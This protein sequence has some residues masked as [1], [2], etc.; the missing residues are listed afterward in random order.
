MRPFKLPDF[1]AAAKNYIEGLDISQ[2][3]HHAFQVPGVK[4][5][6]A[7][8][9]RKELIKYYSGET[10]EEAIRYNPAK[11]G[12]PRSA[13]DTLAKNAINYE[14]NKV[15]ALS[16]LASL[17]GGIAAIGSVSADL[18]S[19]YAHILRIVQK[20][21]YLYGFPEFQLSEDS[22]D[23]ETLNYILVFIGI[24][25]GVHGAFETA[26]MIAA[27]VADNIARKLP[28]KA[29]N[30]SVINPILG[31]I[32][33]RIGSKASTQS[34]ADLFASAVPV[35]GAAFSGGLTYATFKP[36]CYKLRNTLRKYRLCDPEF[37]AEK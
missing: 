4:I 10:V 29:L 5:D 14:T 30:K 15:T 23:E 9:L 21:A 24:M 18:V 8:F 33:S 25:F 20:L 28:Q 37:Y 2:I 6:R 32:L 13:V 17:P 27:K 3:I 22:I 12:I 35:L 36:R 31:K 34:F 26:H 11:A 19:Y 7:A 16:A 1:T